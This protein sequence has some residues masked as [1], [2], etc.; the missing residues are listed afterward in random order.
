MSIALSAFLSFLRELVVDGFLFGGLV[1]IF[2][3]FWLVKPYMAFIV[4]G[5]LMVILSVA[6]LAFSALLNRAPRNVK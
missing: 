5:V 4:V 1:S 6:Y 3:G 2:Y